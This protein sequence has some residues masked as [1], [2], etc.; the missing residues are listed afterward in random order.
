M[1]VCVKHPDGSIH[2]V[3]L[4]IASAV[5]GINPVCGPCDLLGRIFLKGCTRAEWSLITCCM[6]KKTRRVA[7]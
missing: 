6:M 1:C 4:I 7:L 2:Q 5:S 3:L